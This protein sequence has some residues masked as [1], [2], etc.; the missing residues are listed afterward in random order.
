MP[1]GD[2]TGP[3]GYGPMT[4]RGAGFCAGSPVPGYFSPMGRGFRG[5][6]R[7]FGYYGS[8]RGFRHQFYTAGMPFWARDAYTFEPAVDYY[9]NYSEESEVK[10]LSQ[11]AKFLKQELKAI[12]DRLEKLKK[13]KKE[14]PSDK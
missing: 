13:A 9:E 4:G 3:V 7:G 11:E 8:G 12:E 1:R 14:D 6:G 5:R 10:A 2:R